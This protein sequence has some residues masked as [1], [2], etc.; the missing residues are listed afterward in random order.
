MMVYNIINTMTFTC[1]EKEFIRIYV[2]RMTWLKIDDYDLFFTRLMTPT[3]LLSFYI[4]IVIIC[5]NGC[6]IWRSN[7][8]SRVDGGY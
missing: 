2:E 8:H 4:I 5:R 7:K 3:K 6:A 1:R